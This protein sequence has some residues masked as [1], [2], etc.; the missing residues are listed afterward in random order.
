MNGQ[1]SDGAGPGDRATPGPLESAMMG[2]HAGLAE[3]FFEHQRALLDR[4]LP[5]ARAALADFAAR[6]R[7]H[8]ADEEAWVLPA[9]A[10]RGGDATDSPAAQFRTEHRKMLAFVD[11]IEQRL[12]AL[13]TA[14]ADRA[15]L[16]LLDRESWFKNLMAHHDLREG[17][18]LYPKLSAWLSE[19]EQRAILDRCAPAAP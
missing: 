5:A 2:L 17:R 9:Y 6:L 4:D 15:L 18:A 16:E 3:R 13:D 1:A 12:A 14:P 19:A 8:A 7:R 11:E 10:S